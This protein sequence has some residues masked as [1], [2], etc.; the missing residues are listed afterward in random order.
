[1]QIHNLSGYAEDDNTMINLRSFVLIW[2]F[3]LPYSI[4]YADTHD[5]AT[6]IVIEHSN[7]QDFENEIQLPEFDN[8]EKNNDDYHDA[9]DNQ[10]S[11]IN[12]AVDAA[13]SDVNDAVDTTTSDINDAVDATSG[14][15]QS[16]NTNSG[17]NQ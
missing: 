15:N 13:T 4:A 7:T 17:G 10:Q 1:M 8:V 11:N 16:N 14:G 5:D 6:M 9:L 12:D 2:T 3:I